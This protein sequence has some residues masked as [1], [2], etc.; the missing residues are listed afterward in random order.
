VITVDV[1]VPAG[2]DVLRTLK[3]Q[4]FGPL[5]PCAR[6]GASFFAKACR[7]GG[8]EV[9]VRVI[10]G[11]TGV[12]VEIE[13]D[14]AE[15]VA[16]HARALVGAD[17][18]AWD[19]ANLPRP[20]RDGLVGTRLPRVPW[21]TDRLTS[22]VLQQRVPFDEAARAWAMLCRRMGTKAPGAVDLVMPPTFRDLARASEHE[23]RSVGIDHQRRLTL[24]R[25]WEVAHRL[26]PMANE[27]RDEALRKMA[28]I[29]GLGPWT[30]GMMAGFAF[31][32]ADAAPTGD[33]ALPNTVAFAL[34]GEERGDDARMLELLAP[35]AGNRFR[36]I[37]AIHAARIEAPRRGPKRALVRLI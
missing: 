5:D 12:R 17:D 10:G 28:S 3:F 13:G 30:L 18:P 33:Y 32:D 6:A 34:A 29:R 7:I 21:I 11:G 35:Y 31:G 36:V 25:V 22:Q 1:D 14:G 2:I 20:V 4:R 16:P 8:A 19:D 26:D 24:R 23:L 37:R 15:K 27:P 9:V